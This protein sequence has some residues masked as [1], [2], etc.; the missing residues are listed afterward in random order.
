MP[1]V[2]RMPVLEDI[3]AIPGHGPVYQRLRDLLD[4]RQAIALSEASGTKSLG[5]RSLVFWWMTSR[6]SSTPA[7]E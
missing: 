6:V 3:L 5:T 7:E 2:L 1:M 4:S